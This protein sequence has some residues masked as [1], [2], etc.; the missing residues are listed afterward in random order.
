MKTKV[1]YIFICFSLLLSC[2]KRLS[3]IELKDENG[4]LI[5]KYYLD[6]DSL[7]FGTYISYDLEG[8]IFEQS[9]YRS[10]KLD[11]VRTI[12]FSNGKM[13][14]EETYVDGVF[15]GPYKSYY[16]NGQLNLDANYVE[17]VMQGIV[18]RYYSTGELLEE[19]TFTNNEEN[20]PFKEY[21]KNGQV[22]WE[23]AYS[24]GDNEIGTIKAYDDKGNLIKKMECGKYQGEYICQTTWTLDEGEKELT[25][26][27]EE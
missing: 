19:V 7:K 15:H 23:G 2:G 10:G 8:Q 4:N 25:L 9:N 21:Y 11:G 16:D 20:G 6:R 5:E 24:N 12:F 14:I 26:K 22:K 1:L 17:G 27:Y 18:K 3:E 13:E